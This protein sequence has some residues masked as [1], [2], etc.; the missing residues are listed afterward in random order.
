M[1]TYVLMPEAAVNED[2]GRILRKDK[3]GNSGH[4]SVM[5]REAKACTMKKPTNANLGFSIPVAHGCHHATARLRIDYVGHGA[6]TA[7]GGALAQ[8]GANGRSK[9]V[10]LWMTQGHS[11]HDT[12]EAVASVKPGAHA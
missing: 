5:Q 9:A 1:A 12:P 3:V 11:P 6:T 8:C 2:Y 10:Q 4:A 7:R